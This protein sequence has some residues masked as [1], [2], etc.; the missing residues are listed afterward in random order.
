MELL[1][2]SMLNF[3]PSCVV[4]KWLEILA[5]DIMCEFYSQTA[6]S[7]IEDGV[8]ST[9]PYATI[10]GNIVEFKHLSWKL[11]YSHTLREGNSSAN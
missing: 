10:V 3:K 8:S 6:I 9:H 4:Y 1:E 11:S 5:I 7:L 2:M